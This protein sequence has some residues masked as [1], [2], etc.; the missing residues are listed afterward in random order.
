MGVWRV[1]GDDRGSGGRIKASAF[2]DEVARALRDVGAEL[3]E[4]A[5]RAEEGTHAAPVVRRWE[6]DAAMLVSGLLVG[7]ALFAFIGRS[8]PA[9]AAPRAPLAPPTALP[10]ITTQPSATVT[11]TATPQPTAVPTEAQIF[12]PPPTPTVCT[13][14]NAPFQERRQVVPIGSVVGISCESADEARANAESLAA[15]MIATA[16]AEAR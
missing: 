6:R 12:A 11:P 5:P 3:G 4:P 16:T 10:T 14:D 15:A 8:S 2:D 1:T 13:I 7:V 9:P